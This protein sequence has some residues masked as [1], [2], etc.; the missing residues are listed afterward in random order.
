MPCDDARAVPLR[1]QLLGPP[2]VTIDGRPLIVDTRK[3]VALLAYLAVV[4]RPIAR[5]PLAELL[6]PEA[7]PEDGRGALRRTVSV[8]R[9]GLGGS[10]LEVD[11]RQVA[12]ARSGVDLD[13]ARFRAG[14]RSS[15]RG[16]LAAAIAAYEADFL[17]GFSLRDS[18]PFE[19]WQLLEAEA[20]RG[21]L[22]AALRRLVALD[23]GEGRFAEAIASARRLVGLDPLDEAAHRTAM[24]LLAR[25]GDRAAAIRQHREVVRVLEAELGVAPGTETE[26]LY[27][28]IVEASDRAPTDVT[29][30]ATATGRGGAALD[31]ATLIVLA[32][33][34]I[35]GQEVDPD[36]VAAVLE[37]PVGEVERALGV[38][39]DRRLLVEPV[40]GDRYRLAEGAGA[41]RELAAI[42]I[43]QRR[44]LRR[45]A[46]TVLAEAG[47]AARRLGAHGRAA[48]HYRAALELGNGES[49]ALLAAIGDVETLRG[50]YGD[51]LAMYERAAALAPSE[52]VAEFEHRLGALHLR[53]GALELAELHL[54][55]ALARLAAGPSALRASVL[56]DRSLV[57]LRRG[58]ATA[59]AQLAEASA[60]TARA[61][62]DP[63]GEAQAENLLAMVARRAGDVE[64]ARRHLRRSLERAGVADGPWARI[65]ALNSLALLERA[66][67]NLDDALALTDE[68]LRR[69]VVVG[70]RHR[71]AALRNH[72]ADLLHALGRRREADEE[73]VRSVTAFAEVGESGVEPEIW[74][75][76]DW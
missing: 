53:R 12:L 57:A 14:A 64:R 47:D 40:G 44:G 60:D 66:A 61:A 35:L 32:A 38:L 1:I 46:A 41:D 6:W 52:R 65:G 74:K 21:E 68:A 73:L 7:D 49:V 27:R 54:S 43:S 69:C 22:A 31:P 67:G 59:A 28:S 56:A 39:V 11:R 9:G 42:G 36:L 71:E 23:A 58:D 55:A 26:T 37:R 50:R 5:E 51:A 17:E 24:D 48:D 33:A 25:S 19:E 4:D 63:E 30:D 76:V 2:R 10:W 20:L 34:S 70:D 18:P 3:A 16:P 72:R 29:A 13:V 62:A 75:L 8:L 45:R 15:S